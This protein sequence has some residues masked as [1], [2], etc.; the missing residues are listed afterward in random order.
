MRALR[1]KFLTEGYL[2]IENA[3][4][5]KFLNQLISEEDEIIS[6]KGL[7]CYKSL[8]KII[9]NEKLLSCLRAVFDNDLNFNCDSGARINYNAKVPLPKNLLHRDNQN[10]FNP[11]ESF[12]VARCAI[13][14]N[15]YTNLSDCL[16]IVPGSH[17]TLDLNIK[18]FL[19]L[20][21]KGNRFVQER[22]ERL[23][24]RKIKLK[25]TRIRQFFKKK[26]INIITRPGDLVLWNLRTLHQGY[27]KRLKFMKKYCIPNILYH[28]LPKFLL[29]PVPKTRDAIFFV[30]YN[31][32]NDKSGSVKEYCDRRYKAIDKAHWEFQMN[33]DMIEHF[34]K[35]G[36]NIDARGF[37]KLHN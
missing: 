17:K 29:L 21:E 2:K 36:I 1:E 28:I 27:S 31:L 26:K 22:E 25:K 32:K 33:S 7:S 14:L 13:Y 30:I 35:E 18:N 10:V 4:D 19:R 12:E 24:G 37:E 3:F 23:H 6:N 34:K 15:D 16:S 9:I 8:W 11:D 20:F 5:P